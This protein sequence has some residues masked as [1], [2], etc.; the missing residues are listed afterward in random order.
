MAHENSDTHDRRHAHANTHAVNC[1]GF[2]MRRLLAGLLVV[3]LL[4]GNTACSP[5]AAAAFSPQLGTPAPSPTAGEPA[6]SPTPA[7]EAELPEAGKTPDASGAPEEE[8]QFTAAPAEPPTPTIDPLRF[9]FP[10]PRPETDSAW[11]PPLYPTPWAPTPYDHFY[12]TRP[13]A[14]DVV[15]WPL[16]DYRYG[17]V[18]FGSEVHT[19]ID[20]PAPRGTPVLAAGPGKVTWAGYGLYFLNTD[21]TEDPYGLAVAIKHD[22]GH[23]GMTLYTI[24]GH[25][26]E[27][28]V[29]KGQH[30]EGGDV[31][32][33]VGDTGRVTG[34]H[35]HFE[36]RLGKNN[37][38]GSRNPE[39]WL[40]P[41]QGWGVLAGRLTDGYGELLPRQKVQI[42]SYETGQYW[43]V[44]SYGIGSTNSDP[45]YREN[46]VIGDLPAG[47]YEIWIAYQ[48]SVYDLDVEIRPGLV[49]YFTFEGSRGFKNEPPRQPGANFSPPEEA[50]S[51]AA[52]P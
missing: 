26:D 33:L 8:P 10:T 44:S 41:P 19:G 17:G 47:K 43:E 39:L 37:F 31:I 35:L 52:S 29:T 14:A 3:I 11:R 49:T 1:P 15:N 21:E 12:F 20:I 2:D 22:F 45:Y 32:G 38:F 16:A 50:D 23:E 9:V 24:Y 27:V 28:L 18:F 5:L 4:V 36:V 7:V 13:I 40:A 25:M 30:V 48:G 46:L 6:P 42:R 51:D 34:V